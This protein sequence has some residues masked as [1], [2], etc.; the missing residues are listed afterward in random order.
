M[1][2]KR[3]VAGFRFKSQDQGIGNQETG[4]GIQETGGRKGQEPVPGCQL[5]K[6]VGGGRF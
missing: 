4:S 1:E 5:T 3:T 2:G 6:Q